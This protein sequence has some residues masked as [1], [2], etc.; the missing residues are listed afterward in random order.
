MEEGYL[1]CLYSENGEKNEH[2]NYFINCYKSL[3]ELVPHCNVTLYTNIEFE[4]IYNINIIFDKN[5]D[6]RLICKAKGL[7]LSPY[8]KTILLDTDIIIHRNII[9]DIFLVLDEFD[10]T[11]CYGN[12]KPSKGGIFPD[13]NTGLLGVKNNDFTKEQI[14]IWISKYVKGNDQ[15]PFRDHVFMKNK[16]NFHILPTYFMY[17][18][19][20]YRDY[21]MQ[22]VLTHSFFSKDEVTKKI[23][24]EWLIKKNL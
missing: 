6:K 15:R 19:H 7:L 20:H 12:S 8:K 11:C 1:F 13:L 14:N 2:F 22:A 18:Y 9:N 10:F 21:P 3:V 24:D 23:I 17:R 4:N 5:I 16:S